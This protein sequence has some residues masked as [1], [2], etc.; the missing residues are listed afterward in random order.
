MFAGG[1]FGFM[2]GGLA[3][4]IPVI[5]LVYLLRPTLRTAFGVGTT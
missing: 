5:I 1:V 4:I 2:C 3:L